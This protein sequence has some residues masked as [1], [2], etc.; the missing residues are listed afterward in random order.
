MKKRA[1]SIAISFLLI[2]FFT[3]YCKSPT[4]SD[5][6]LPFSAS[7]SDS[8]STKSSNSSVGTSG[9]LFQLIL[10]DKPIEDAKEIWITINKIRVHKASPENFIVVSEKEQEFDLLVLK[11]N[12]QAIV[13]AELDAGHYN[14]IRMA[15]IS[16]RL[17]FD[18]D[19]V[20]VEYELKV[21]SN[22]IKIPVQF[23]VEQDGEVQII[24]DFDAEKSIHVNKKGK[25]DNYSLRPVIKVLGVTY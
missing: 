18:E 13:E 15:V 23:E 25:K 2:L 12:P 11:D 5:T 24:L 20:E 7:K 17:V 8:N 10:K 3:N 4:S 9:G 19:D 16:G 14:Q 1:I 6:P 22:E 21:S